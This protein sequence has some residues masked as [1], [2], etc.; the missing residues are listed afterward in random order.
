MT[1][2][3][4]IP[5][6]IDLGRHFDTAISYLWT[7]W[8]E[9]QEMVREGRQLL[10]VE[11]DRYACGFPLPTFQ[12]PLCWDQSQ[13]V[14]FVE[15]AWLGLSLGSFSHH[16]MEWGQGG[17]AKP[18]SGWLIDGQQRLTSLQRYWTDEFRVF[19]AYWSDLDLVEQRRF[20][21]IRLPHFEVALWDESRIRDLYNRLAF[22]GVPHTPE[23]RA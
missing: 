11:E 12:R 22:G 9:H 15:S 7:N 23:Q 16:I 3:A 14:A 17:V 5:P 4:R 1:T 13:E 10:T 21:N 19:G 8:R 2:A 18:F 20:K 6:A